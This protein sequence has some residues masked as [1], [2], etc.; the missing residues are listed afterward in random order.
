LY[1]PKDTP[2]PI[3]DRLTKALNNAL[4]DPILV[5]RFGEMDAS[6]ATS[7]IANPAYASKFLVIDID[8]W[9]VAM[10]NAGVKPQ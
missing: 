6:V 9:K 4:K 7:A 2:K 8:R 1:A 3:I 10:K 5:R